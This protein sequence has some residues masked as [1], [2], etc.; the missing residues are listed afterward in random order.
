M[1]VSLLFHDSRYV[2]CPSRKPERV[3]CAECVCLIF[4]VYS[5]LQRKR[6]EGIGKRRVHSLQNYFHIFAL[7]S[8]ICF[9]LVSRRNVHHHTQTNPTQP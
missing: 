2:C 7:N 9:C 4:A 8:T 1:L 6:L 3:L 5:N